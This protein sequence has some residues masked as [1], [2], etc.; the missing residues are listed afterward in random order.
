VKPV[1]FKLWVNRVQR[2]PPHLRDEG[3]LAPAHHGVAV[4][5]AFESKR[6]ETRFSLYRF[7]G[8]MKPGAFK[9]DGSGLFSLYR[10]HHGLHGA[11]RR[12]VVLERTRAQHGV[13]LSCGGVDHYGCHQLVLLTIHPAR[14]VAL[15]MWTISRVSAWLCGPQRWL[16]GP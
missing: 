1:A 11:A 10:A 8:L 4:Q 16:Y 3:Q 9:R 5:V 12:G 7:Q 15:V 6:L 14:V 2:A 13:G